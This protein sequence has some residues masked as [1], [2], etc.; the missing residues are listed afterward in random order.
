MATTVTKKWALAPC[1]ALLRTQLNS[2]Y[3]LRDKSSDGSIA[4]AFHI[5]NGKSDHIPNSQGIVTAID[6][7]NDPVS[8]C[9][10]ALIAEH[11]RTSRDSRVKYLIFN[12]FMLRS[13]DKPGILAWTWSK[14]TGANS[15]S[16]HLHIS[17]LADKVND[18]QPWMIG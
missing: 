10:M 3:P 17:V 18:V 15:H 7:T 2:K 16:H 13:Y 12:Y 5:A 8:E 1:L 6:I 4:D 9:H 14:Y 11:I